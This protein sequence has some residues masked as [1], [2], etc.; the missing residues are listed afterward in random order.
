MGRATGHHQS[1]G[2]ATRIR[3]GAGG[4]GVTTGTVGSSK[5]PFHST[6]PTAYFLPDPDSWAAKAPA[7]PGPHAK[8]ARVPPHGPGGPKLDPAWIPGTG[9]GIG[10]MLERQGIECPA[11][12]ARLEQYARNP[13]AIQG[14]INRQRLRDRVE[15]ERDRRLR[16]AVDEKVE[17]RLQKDEELR[18]KYKAAGAVTGYALRRGLRSTFAG[19][20]KPGDGMERPSRSKT[21]RPKKQ[22]LIDSLLETELLPATSSPEYQ[23]HLEYLYKAMTFA[24]LGE[25][26]V[27]FLDMLLD[28][29][30]DERGMPDPA[31]EPEAEPVA[32]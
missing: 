13:E 10:A 11:T 25:G 21:A 14:Y 22:G 24:A 4:G 31:P 27:G 29:F 17:A 3:V 5:S 30:A 2:K 9:I 1:A 7:R 23:D 12:A 15:E 6:D 18:R 19:A 32:A 28:P 20:Y 16:E 8:S 26:V